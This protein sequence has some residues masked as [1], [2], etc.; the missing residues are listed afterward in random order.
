MESLM[1]FFYSI[2]FLVCFSFSSHAL[3]YSCID[4]KHGHLSKM[5]VKGESI[6]YEDQKGEPVEYKIVENSKT[7]LMAIS[8]VST[9]EN[10]ILNYVFIIK[11]KSLAGIKPPD[12]IN[13]KAKFRESKLLTLKILRII[14]KHYLK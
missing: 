10:P 8:K 3:E 6:K 12:E 13:E 9:K 14:K 4:K 5:T 11:D 2:L 7:A 1:K